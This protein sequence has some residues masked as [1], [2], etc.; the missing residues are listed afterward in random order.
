MLISPAVRISP[1]V[2]RA[3]NDAACPLPEASLDILLATDASH[4]ARSA[5]LVSAALARRHGVAPRV[6]SVL[7]PAP[8]PVAPIPDVA[9][10]PVAE[11][12]E[13]RR[14]RR[15][16]ETRGLLAAPTIEGQAWPVEV[17]AGDAATEIVAAARAAGSAL[18]VMGLHRHSALDRI[19]RDDTTMR[20]IRS[21][22]VPV[23][24]VTPQLTTLPRRVVV[25]VDFSRA[26]VNAARCALSVMDEGGTLHLVHVR[27]PMHRVPEEAEGLE[28]I[29]SQGVVGAFGRLVRELSPK[30]GVRIETVIL[31][32]DPVTELLDF[33][34]R[35]DADLISVGRQR[36]GVVGRML[37]GS[38]S[39]ALVRAARVSVLVT[40]PGPLAARTSRAAAPTA[41][42]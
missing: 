20:V 14:N 9:F 38:V 31:Q 10:Y 30:T 24:A 12:E 19:F 16:E 29:Y 5:A 4:C 28:V 42:A 36:H 26:S 7:Q 40:P 11:L 8:Y 15:R 3:A 22:D 35:A 21:S 37:L 18:V 1:V 33:A 13:R 32:G 23:L 17:T 2:T 34:A 41:V 6:L 25:A 39:A 27:P